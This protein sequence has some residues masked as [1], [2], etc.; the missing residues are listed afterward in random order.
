MYNVSVNLLGL[1]DV[2]AIYAYMLHLFVQKTVMRLSCDVWLQHD[3]SQEIEDD[4]LDENVFENDVNSSKLNLT[5]KR[6][7]NRCPLLRYIAM[8]IPIFSQY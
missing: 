6:Q 3:E 1:S 5:P 2:F 7:L 4:E 8:A